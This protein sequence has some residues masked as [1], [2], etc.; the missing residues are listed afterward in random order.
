MSELTSISNGSRP[1]C[2]G[3]VAWRRAG[4]ALL[5]GGALLVALQPTAEAKP[6]TADEVRRSCKKISLCPNQFQALA[7]FCTLSGTTPPSNT[8][9]AQVT[10]PKAAE[11][12]AA[13]CVAGPAP[14]AA[15][16]IPDF[17][18]TPISAPGFNQSARL[19]GA[20]DF[21]VARA[22]QELRAW[23][24][25]RFIEKICGNESKIKIDGELVFK[26]SCAIASGIEL[27]GFLGGMT[28][29]Q[30]A[31]REDLAHLPFHMLKHMANV[32][33][34][35]KKDA[36]SLFALLGKAIESEIGGSGAIA[37]IQSI[38]SDTSHVPISCTDTPA[39][40]ISFQAA[41][42]LG[43]L[44]V[45]GP[46]SGE[47]DIPKDDTSWVFALMALAI[48][49]TDAGSGITKGWPA[50]C[51]PVGQVPFD[52]EKTFRLATALK[53]LADNL[54][55]AAAQLK[56]APAGADESYRLDV[57]AGMLRATIH[58][59]VTV[60]D[61]YDGGKLLSPS[62]KETLAVCETVAG[63]LAQANYAGAVITIG[64]VVAAA[65]LKA[66]FPKEFPR[67]ASFG[68]DIA[69]AT[70]ADAA[71]AAFDRFA[72]PVGSYKRKRTG[73]W[74]AGVNGYLGFGGALEFAQ[75]A[76]DTWTDAKWGFS[77]GF[78]A[79]FGIEGGYG[80][81]CGSIALLFQ[82]VDLG[83]LASWRI[84]GDHDAASAT[85]DVGVRQVFSPGAHI[86]WG[87]PNAPLSL[88]AG[89]SLAPSLR[90]LKNLVDQD[91][92]A[93]RVGVNLAVDIPIFP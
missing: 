51:V 7:N 17:E 27:P 86:V 52:V 22:E 42:L 79:S 92:N 20:T 76:P 71:A 40:A 1:P 45:S 88:A 91:A 60:L 77:P 24:V 69:Q 87:I 28:T 63:D 32:G 56:N 53:V 14:A 13:K 50:A 81:E 21:L 29:Y 2:N 46:T 90:E 33:P 48:N 49:A 43:S 54:A 62:I 59:F 23:A 5:I 36:Y 35:E 4:A 39:A 8:A 83:V 68:V 66:A 84:R 15:M 10:V 31:M 74:Y 65:G 44:L 34:I 26:K 41:A 58:A 19:W 37:A 25:D 30:A 93:L 78:W 11:L 80:G 89:V 3:D 12:S 61:A 16:V 57:Y 64:E 55:G 38:A 6:I 73:G 82:A 85:P 67:I 70:T 75:Q 47:V 72:A 18:R 9:W